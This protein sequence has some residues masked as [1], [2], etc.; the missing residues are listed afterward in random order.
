LQKSTKP[1]PKKRK[2]HRHSSNATQKQQTEA[3]GTKL[4][5]FKTSPFKVTTLAGYVDD[6]TEGSSTDLHS[7]KAVKIQTAIVA[8]VSHSETAAGTLHDPTATM[9]HQRNIAEVPETSGVM[10]G[11]N[12][13]G[14]LAVARLDCELE[15]AIITCASMP[16]NQEVPLIK[17]GKIICPYKNII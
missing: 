14:T 8:P 10:L 2:S 13:N 15:S 7:P 4:P 16:L 9:C 5:K 11:T 17:E 1:S 6:E 12:E 3:D